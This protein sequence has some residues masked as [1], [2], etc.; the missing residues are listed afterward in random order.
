MA[1]RISVSAI[2]Y[3][4]KRCGRCGELKPHTEFG[5][6]KNLSG[7][8]SWQCKDCRRKQDAEIRAKREPG[9][10][11]DYWLKRKYGLSL[12]EY[13]ALLAGQG[14]GCAICGAQD[15]RYHNSKRMKSALHVDH[16]HAT[17]TVRGI[18]CNP[19]N[20]SLGHFKD[21]AD[22]LRRA[23]AYLDGRLI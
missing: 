9:W 10:G 21:D 2:P 7:G 23:A 8:L 18:L 22:L 11:R 1:K 12:D 20:V 5:K 19:C 17:G 3:E 14:G 13:E 15:A 4:N 16:D 6:D